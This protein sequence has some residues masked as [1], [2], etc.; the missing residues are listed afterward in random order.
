MSTNQDTLVVRRKR[1]AF[2]AWHRGTKEMDFILGTFADRQLETLDNAG[3]D[4][5]EALIDVPDQDLYNWVTGREPV[6]E[7][8]DN[9]IMAELKS[10]RFAPKDYPGRL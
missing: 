7:E 4:R 10:F 2:R 3:L 9:D 5:F 8:Y 6:P 1:L